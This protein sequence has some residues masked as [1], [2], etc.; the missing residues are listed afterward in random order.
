[1]LFKFDLQSARE[2]LKKDILQ[3]Y[4]CYAT[5][6]NQRYLPRS[7]GIIDIGHIGTHTYVTTRCCYNKEGNLKS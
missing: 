4:F 2:M 1:M 5:F 7:I 3:R 6:V